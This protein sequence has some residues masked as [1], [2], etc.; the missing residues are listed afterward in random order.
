MTNDQIEHL[1]PFQ[2]SVIEKL[3]PHHIKEGVLVKVR[4]RQDE[5]GDGGKLSATRKLLRYK[6]AERLTQTFELSPDDIFRGNFNAWLVKDVILQGHI[7]LTEKALVY[8]AF[9][10]GDTALKSPLIQETLTIQLRWF[11]GEHWV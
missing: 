2:K 8:F 11:I 3:D 7:Y 1:T 10:P 4:N 9:L 6:I 5:P